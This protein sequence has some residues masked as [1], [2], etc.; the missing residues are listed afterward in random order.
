MGVSVSNKS[1]A[2]LGADRRVLKMFS[3][4]AAVPLATIQADHAPLGT[5]EQV[6][7]AQ[8]SSIANAMQ[9]VFAAGFVTLD[10][11]GN[12]ETLTPFQTPQEAKWIEI[13]LARDAAEFGGFTWDGSR[14]DSD[15]ISQSRI[16]GAVQLAAMG[17]GFEIDWTLADNSARTLDAAAMFAVGA[18]LG[19]HVNAQHAKG[20]DLRTRIDAATPEEIEA[21]TW[22]APW[23]I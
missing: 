1:Y 20:R 13:K 16:Q 15:Q 7:D 18:A 12:V 10:L 17:P 23:P 14:F 21:I 22:D 8:A 3:A 5:V 9:S 4:P 11:A 6:T 19:Q 2:V